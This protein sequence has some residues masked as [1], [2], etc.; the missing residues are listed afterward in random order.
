MLFF[1]RKLLMETQYMK[2]EKVKLVWLKWRW[3]LP[4]AY[5]AS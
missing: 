1:Q 2:N 3:G 4:A 5:L